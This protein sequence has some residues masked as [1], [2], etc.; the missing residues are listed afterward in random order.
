VYFNRT[1][2][3]KALHAPES[4]DWSECSAEPVFVGGDGGPEQEGDFS[5]NPIEKVLPQVIE[6]TNRVL[7][8]NGDYDMIIITNGTLLSVSIS[9]PIPDVLWLMFHR[10]KI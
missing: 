1:D 8:G 5:A 2:V 3:K 10:S 4:V 6:A 7:I 9:V